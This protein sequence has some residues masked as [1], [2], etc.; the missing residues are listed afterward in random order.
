ML[1]ASTAVLSRWLNPR[2]FGVAALALT[3]VTL[4]SVV[5]GAPF[6]EALAQR[7]VLR[8]AHLRAALTACWLASLACVLAVH[9][10]RLRA[11]ARL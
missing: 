4:A 8:L 7:K 5:V 11:G 1:A 10:A 6:E 2:D 9:S 3:V